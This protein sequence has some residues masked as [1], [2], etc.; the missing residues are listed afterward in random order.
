MPQHNRLGWHRAKLVRHTRERYPHTNHHSFWMPQLGSVFHMFV[1]LALFFQHVVNE[2][3]LKCWRLSVVN[4]AAFVWFMVCCRSLPLYMY[5]WY[6][7]PSQFSCLYNGPVSFPCSDVSLQILP[8]G[9]YFKPIHI[10]SYTLQSIWY[11]I[12]LILT[13]NALGIILC[14]HST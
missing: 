11:T 5:V 8:H 9:K 2:K 1:S 14:T 7:I 4:L 12:D 3:R 13:L 6:L 10:M